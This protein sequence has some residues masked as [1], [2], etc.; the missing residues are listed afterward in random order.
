M[1]LEKDAKSG[2]TVTR[3]CNDCGKV[4]TLINFS[5]KNTNRSLCK[6]C[7]R[8]DS[9]EVVKEKL[10][11]YGF[12][13]VRGKYKNN[14]S[15]L[16]LKCKCGELFES[17]THSIIRGKTG[18]SSCYIKYKS[19][20]VSG[21]NNPMAGR[22]GILNPAYNHGLSDE[23]RV[24]RRLDKRLTKW[25][26]IVKEEANFKCDTCGK[27]S[28]GDL[29]SHHLYNYADNLELALDISNGVCLCHSC[30]S[31]FHKNYGKKF[32]T[33]EQYIQ[34]KEDYNGNKK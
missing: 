6:G 14:R 16:I 10:A 20:M 32:N 29:E 22:F 34:F 11:Q 19:E 17:D 12:E 26:Y 8:K 33:K 4:D 31:L 18:C 13:Y 2:D 27:P 3:V 9:I 24:R 1:I 7:N 15:T 5:K 23:N 30:H 21:S 25:S 28:D